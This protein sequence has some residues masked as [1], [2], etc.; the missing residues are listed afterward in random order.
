[1][2]PRGPAKGNGNGV[3]LANVEASWPSPPDWVIVLARA[4]DAAGSSQG[5][6]AD[7]LNY[8]KSTVSNV[9]N[10]KYGGDLS[11]VEQAVRGALM[12]ETLMC[13]V[14]GEIKRN[15]CL[16]HQKR[17]RKFAATSSIRVRLHRTCPTCPNFTLKGGANAE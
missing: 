5:V 3:A 16:E 4:C 10:N 17:S 12:S 7:R 9:L 1:M 15:I 14:V 11:R 6:V 8:S 2:S 13:P